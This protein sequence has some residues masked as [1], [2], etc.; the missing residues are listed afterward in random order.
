MEEKHICMEPVVWRTYLTLEGS[1]YICRYFPFITALNRALKNCRCKLLLDKQTVQSSLAC[2][3]SWSTH[4]SVAFSI[5]GLL[6]EKTFS[7]LLSATFQLSPFLFSEIRAVS[8]YAKDSKYALCS[9]A[10]HR[11][12]QPRLP[13]H[14]AVTV[15]SVA[16]GNFHLLRAGL[17]QQRQSCIRGLLGM[18]N[19]EGLRK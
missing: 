9:C 17:Q 1:S 15:Q 19:G 16:M 4:F 12:T 8:S 13:H 11:N 3:I 10:G 7:K 14:V 2:H 6:R 18:N 5:R